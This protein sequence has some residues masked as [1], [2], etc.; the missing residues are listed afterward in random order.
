MLRLALQEALQGDLSL[1]T[2]LG[3]HTDIHQDT[4][5]LVPLADAIQISGAAFVVDDKGSNTMSEIFFE[6]E[7]SANPSVAIFKRV[8]AFEFHME[9]QN[10]VKADIFLRFVFFNQSGHG[11]PDL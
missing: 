8:D 7:K 2:H 4:A 11:R 9:I 3:F 1:E 10:L 5:V 6:H